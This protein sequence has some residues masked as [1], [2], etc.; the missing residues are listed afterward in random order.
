MPEEKLSHRQRSVPACE[1][2]QDASGESKLGQGHINTY[3]KV[4]MYGR[5]AK[6]REERKKN[7]LKEPARPSLAS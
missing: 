1:T 4:I 2:R 6:G 5:S 7:I 3:K